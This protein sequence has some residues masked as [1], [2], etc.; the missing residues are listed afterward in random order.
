VA[1]TLETILLKLKAPTGETLPGRGFYQLEEDALYVPVGEHNS[2]R[3]FFSY[4]E[5]KRVRFDIDRSGGLMLI[6][7]DFARRRWAVDDSLKAPLIIEPADIRWLDFRQKM[8]DPE[9]ITN[10]QRSLLLIQF[11]PNQS[12]RWYSLAEDVLIQIDSN[13]HLNALMITTIEDDLAGRQIAA[14]RKL[15]SRDQDSVTDTSQ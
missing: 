5:S 9:L 13:C 11:A 15:I 8:P 4:L 7:V 3:R 1:K 12:S 6:E 10:P 2:E 14:F